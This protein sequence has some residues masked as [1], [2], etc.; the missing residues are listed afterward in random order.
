VVTFE[1]RPDVALE[2]LRPGVGTRLIYERADGQ[3][4]Y[5]RAEGRLTARVNY[6]GLAFGARLDVGAVTSDGP[7]QQFFELGSNQNLPGYAYKQFAG[8]QAAVLRGQAFYGFGILGVPLRITPRI[9]LP[10]ISPGLAVGVQAGYARA[11]TAAAL[12]TVQVLGSEPTG[13]VRSSA[14]VTLRFFG[15]AIGVGFARPLDYPAGWR[16]ILELGQ[17][18]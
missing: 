14:A 3:L 1:W 2:F 6:G 16:W 7:P 11:S 8:D 17:R 4:N 12:N 15:Q 13:H 10:P 18:F 5:Q 9:W